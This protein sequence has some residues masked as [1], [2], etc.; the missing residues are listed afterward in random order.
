MLVHMNK[1][2][3]PW[4]LII[5]LCIPTLCRA[6]VGLPSE[7]S[8][9]VQQNGFDN[10]GIG[11]Y[12]REVN[13]QE[14][15]LAFQANQALNPASVI[16]LVTTAAS[17]AQLGQ[18]YQWTTEVWYT[19]TIA[20]DR[21]KGDL[22][23]RG[24][25]DPYLTPERFWRM[26]N[27]IAIFGIK[28]INGNVYFDNRYFDPGK[29]DY[30]A[31]D[32]QPYRT[33]N[34]GPNAVLIGFQATEFHFDADDEQVKITPFPMSPKLTINNKVKLVNGRCGAWQ[35]RLDIK[36]HIVQDG[37]QVDFEGRYSRACGKRTLYRRVSEVSDHYRHF[38]LPLWT[39]IGGTITGKVSEGTLPKNALT[40]FDDASISMA[41]AVRLI[42]K[43]SNNVMTRQVL[44]SLGARIS[45][46]PGT[47]EKGIDAVNT[48]LDQTGL[49]AP[50]L[51]LDNGAGLSR[52]TRISAENLGRLL[53]YVYQQPY[54]PEF[55]A[56]LPVAGYDGTMAHRFE[57]EAVHGRAHIKTGLLD[58][59]QTMAGY[60]TSKSGKRYVLVM[61]HN[62]PRAHT[63]AAEKLQNEVI[64]WVYHH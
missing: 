62:H 3:F 9:A 24:N 37:L 14:P 10:K 8:K 5:G 32:E 2:C 64:R 40:V 54:M 57:G 25:G 30:A 63:K 27:R 48:W 29:I 22:Y 46:P 16:K 1:T 45:G 23:L 36:P 53:H 13:S 58:F 61:L 34:V 31:F 11:L 33:Y 50:N 28:H 26:L 20:K 44:L 52:E 59:V 47:T 18:G 6:D 19:G 60:V 49:N 38:F 56:S 42:N 35:K 12:V 15:T 7:I 55:I 17:L 41:E 4:I 21:L 39:Q 51:Q 43:F